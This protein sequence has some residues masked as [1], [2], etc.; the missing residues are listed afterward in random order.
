M[1]FENRES[2]V[3]MEWQV[4]RTGGRVAPEEPPV[5]RFSTGTWPERHR[6]A[7]LR[8]VFGKIARYDF[9]PLT[10]PFHAAVTVRAVGT[11]GFVSIDHSLMRVSR[12]RQL[13]ADGD[14]AL[15]LQISGGGNTTSQLGR[16][17]TLAPGDAILASSSDVGTFTCS[18]AAGKSTIISLSRRELLPLIEDFD[19]VLLAPVPAQAPALQLL[20]RYVALFDETPTLVPQLQ[21][22]A[23]AHVYDL[24]AMALGATRD[25]RE[26]ATGRGIRAAR[27][28]AAQTFVMRNLARHDLSAAT[29]ARHLGVTRRYVHMLFATEERSFSEFVLAERLARAHRT[30]ADPR[31]AGR[32]I[33]AVAFESG[34]GD[35]SHFNRTFRRRFGMTPSQSR[36]ASWRKSE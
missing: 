13:L 22:L 35:L 18:S 12:T 8:D 28:H 5:F 9:E 24:T 15:V 25:A 2:I 26:V 1:F 6:L 4:V 27:L 10:D 36:E 29:V 31:W 11:V 30:L 14:D 23:V 16:E 34:F 33:S 32:A 7:G 19:A 20:A 3:N 17:V 21:R